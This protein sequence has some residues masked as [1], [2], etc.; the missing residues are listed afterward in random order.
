MAPADPRT[1]ANDVWL[2]IPADE[3]GGLPDRFD[4]V[5]WDAGPEF[6]ADPARCAFYVAPYM[7][8]R[9]CAYAR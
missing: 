7:K 1:P 8:I 5:H 6:P 2:P 4:Y 3:I 9:R